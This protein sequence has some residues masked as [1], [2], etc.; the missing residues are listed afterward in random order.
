MSYMEHQK[1]ICY[2]V[3]SHNAKNIKQVSLV[4]FLALRNPISVMYIK[5]FRCKY[6][7]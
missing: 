3:N 2:A 7:S 1:Q 5:N 4:R 6:V